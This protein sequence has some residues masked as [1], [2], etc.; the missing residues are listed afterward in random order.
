MSFDIAVIT[1]IIDNVRKSTGKK[2]I[3]TPKDSLPLP[4]SL[5]EERSSK[6][7]RVEYSPS[8]CSTGDL[9]FELLRSSFFNQEPMKQLLVYLN[10]N[11]SKDD[12]KAASW[13]NLLLSLNWTMRELQQKGLTASTLLNDLL[14]V[15]VAYLQDG[16]EA[17]H[18]IQNQHYRKA[19]AA[20]MYTIYLLTKNVLH[21][22]VGSVFEDFYKKYDPE[23]RKI[24]SEVATLLQ[25]KQDETNAIGG[26][27]TLNR[28]LSLFKLPNLITQK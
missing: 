10:E 6:Q 23:S 15:N 22:D 24:G 7:I 20:I 4:A 18:H 3:L 13:I 1:D 19:Y 27:E 26:K 25:S 21:D 28:L 8:R 16:D 12:Q 2:I 11:A 9:A 14:K 5:V 17:Y